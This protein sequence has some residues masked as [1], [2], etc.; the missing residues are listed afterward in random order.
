MLLIFLIL[1]LFVLNVLWKTVS[2]NLLGTSNFELQSE[3]QFS[4]LYTKDHEKCES[5]SFSKVEVTLFM[6]SNLR[7]GKRYLSTRSSDE[8]NYSLSYQQ[9]HISSNNLHNANNHQDNPNPSLWIFQNETFNDLTPTWCLFKD[10]DLSY[11]L[12]LT[13]NNNINIVDKKQQNPTSIVG[14]LL[15]G[16]YFVSLNQKY[17]I[18]YDMLTLCQSYSQHKSSNKFVNDNISLKPLSNSNNVLI[19]SSEEDSFNSYFDLRSLSKLTTAVTVTNIQSSIN[20]FIHSSIEFIRSSIPPSFFSGGGV[21]SNN[22]LRHPSAMP[23]SLPTSLPTSF[24]SPQP[25]SQPSSMPTR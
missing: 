18:N 6:A 2:S 24:P 3:D 14:V 11:S 25:S 16:E 12:T 23:T 4:L 21:N 5:S 1:T 13:H 20:H 19:K 8:I 15:C 9:Q 7:N 22:K 17:E 10:K